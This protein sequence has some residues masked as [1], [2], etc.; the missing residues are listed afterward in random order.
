MNNSK[1]NACGLV[2][3]VGDLACRRCGGM[4]GMPV[5]KSL[6][7]QKTTSPRYLVLL[8]FLVLALG[9]A[10]WFNNIKKSATDSI[11]LD[12][13][14]WHELTM[15]SKVNPKDPPVATKPRSAT[16][17][18][19]PETQEWMKQQQWRPLPIPNITPFPDEYKK[20]EELMW[21]GRDLSGRP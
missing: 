19:P 2:N 4:L 21:K 10:Y 15:D 7:E 20:A 14:E 17:Q 11:H 9:F 13:E 8:P 16:E 3:P 12:K 6:I 1:C 18:I 5:R